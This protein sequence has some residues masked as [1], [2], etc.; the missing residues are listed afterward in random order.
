[1]PPPT[2]TQ[3]AATAA[4]SPKDPIIEITLLGDHVMDGKIYTRGKVSVAKSIADRLRANDARVY[5]A[6]AGGLD[7]DTDRLIDLLRRKTTEAE[8]LRNDVVELRAKLADADRKIV[9]LGKAATLNKAAPETTG[10]PMG[11]QGQ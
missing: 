10:T 3:P 6:P 9:E 1:M 2:P 5:G 4:P 7:T 8:N 11:F